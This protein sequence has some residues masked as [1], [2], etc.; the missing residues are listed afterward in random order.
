MVFF[1]SFGCPA[2]YLERCSRENPELNEC[3]RNSAN[4]LAKYLRQGVPELE[5]D[6]VEP[7][8]I[9]EIG[10]ALGSGPDGYRAMF[11]NIEAFG[12]SNLTVTNVR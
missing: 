11:R 9:D 10:I 6:D 2:Y 12:V 4:R 7:V 1:V 3:L 5:M 8:L